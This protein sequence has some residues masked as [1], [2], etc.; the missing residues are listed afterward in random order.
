MQA[1]E[2]AD[3]K[4]P[5]ALTLES[6]WSSTLL[7]TSNT[8]PINIRLSSGSTVLLQEDV[9]VSTDPT[10]TLS[11]LFT[12]TLRSHVAHDG[13]FNIRRDKHVIILYSFP[14]R[15]MFVRVSEPVAQV[16]STTRAT[17]GS[18]GDVG[19]WVIFCVE[20]NIPVL[21]RLAEH[22]IYVSDVN[23]SLTQVTTCIER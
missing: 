8:L 20:P 23:V 15:S 16:I 19:V 1:A 4:R 2:A 18:Q 5:P 22:K 17:G 9:L 3:N 14:K 12:R 7:L 11:A 10:D 21:R 13:R 6:E